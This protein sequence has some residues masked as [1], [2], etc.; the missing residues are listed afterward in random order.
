[1]DSSGSAFHYYKYK[2]NTDN[3]V[4]A[5]LKDFFVLGN[6]GSSATHMHLDFQ[7]FAQAKNHL[8]DLVSQFPCRSHNQRLYLGNLYLDT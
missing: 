4:N 8:M 2:A 3:N 7:E 1:M 6:H 5:F